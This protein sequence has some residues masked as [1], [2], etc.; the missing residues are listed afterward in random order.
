MSSNNPVKTN[1]SVILKLRKFDMNNQK[2]NLFLADIE[3]EKND[4]KKFKLELKNK[5]IN[6]NKNNIN[7]NNINNNNSPN[8]KINNDN[9]I[10]NNINNIKK[11]KTCIELCSIKNSSN[12]SNSSNKI[13]TQINLGTI[14]VIS[15]SFYSFY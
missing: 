11:E 1:N 8:N 10:K 5:N 12:S 6:K 14:L 3:A 2:R 15:H 4:L 13:I 7:T 9:H